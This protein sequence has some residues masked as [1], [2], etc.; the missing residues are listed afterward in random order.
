ME[1]KMARRGGRVVVADRWFA[2]SK[3]CS[4]CGHKLESLPLATRAWVCP[5]CGTQHDRDVNAAINLRHLAV[6][7]TVSACG[8]ESS[9]LGRKT[10]AKLASGKQEASSRFT[11]I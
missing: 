1:Y 3:T 11:H 5:L 8:E 10:K 2:S 4:C 7:S 9:G 6:S